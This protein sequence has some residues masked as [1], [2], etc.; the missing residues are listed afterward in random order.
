MV[1]PETGAPEWPWHFSVLLLLK[2]YLI[3]RSTFLPRIL[4]VFSMVAGLGWLTLLSPTLGNRLF[5]YVA[6]F[7]LLVAA[8]QILWLLVFGLNE[9]RW[10][11]QANA[12]VE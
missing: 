12:A 9:Q 4:G 1:K 3:F 5:L 6:A 2:G 7:G 8:A 10:K 11:E